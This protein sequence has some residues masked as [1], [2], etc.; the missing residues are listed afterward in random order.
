ML[1]F[2]LR[3]RNYKAHDM[4]TIAKKKRRRTRIYTE[5]NKEQAELA[6]SARH[7]TSRV[8]SGCAGVGSRT[9]AY[10]GCRVMWACDACA[11]AGAAEKVWQC[12]DGLLQ[13]FETAASEHAT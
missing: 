5:K 10:A 7:L 12:D 8:G 1:M 13:G 9:Y 3:T 2:S 6:R 11:R 4:Y